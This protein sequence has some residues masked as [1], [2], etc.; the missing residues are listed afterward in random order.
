MRL[1]FGKFFVY[2]QDPDVADMMADMVEPVY[3]VL[4]TTKPS[5]HPPPR[6][7]PHH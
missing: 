2:V 5:S 3:W 4:G 6:T 1:Y 7:S